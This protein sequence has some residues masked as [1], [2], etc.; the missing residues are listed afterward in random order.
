MSAR[1]PR[2]IQP[3][4][5]ELK[6]SEDLNRRTKQEW[7]ESAGIFKAERFEIAG[8]LFNCSADLLL[9]QQEVQFRLDAYLRPDTEEEKIN[10]DSAE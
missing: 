1:N 8:A 4:L 6:N 3:G 10:V 9:S 7:I 2:K 5:E